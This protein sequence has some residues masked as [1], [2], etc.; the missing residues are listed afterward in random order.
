M[1]S[2][3]FSAP[4]IRIWSESRLSHSRNFARRYT[5]RHAS[6]ASLATLAKA[7]WHNNEGFVLLLGQIIS[8]LFC[9]AREAA[10]QLL[11]ADHPSRRSCGV[12]PVQD[13][14]SN[15]F[16]ATVCLLAQNQCQ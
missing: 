4:C 10:L 5:I 11:M 14:Y 6:L 15:A 2:S 9:A 3:H 16:C 8:C 13:Y 12:V 1:T 7:A